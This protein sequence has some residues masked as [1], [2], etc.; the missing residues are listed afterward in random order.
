MDSKIKKLF[1]IL[2]VFSQFYFFIGK[3][4]AADGYFYIT[5][6]VKSTTCMIN[7]TAQ[8]S[9][10]VAVPIYLGFVSAESYSSA[11]KFGGIIQNNANGGLMMLTG[12]TANTSVV[13]TLDGTGNFNQV[14]NSYSNLIP[15]GSGGALNLEVQ[16]VNPLTQ[17]VLSPSGTNAIAVTTDSNGIASIPVG[18]RFYSAGKVIPGLFTANAGF[19][20]AYP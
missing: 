10:V 8:G 18:A 6:G 9:S 17:V 13:L 4:V 19:N 20:L 5:G 15:L 2:L 12:C 11:G 7:G 1:H 16:I 3:T 14:N